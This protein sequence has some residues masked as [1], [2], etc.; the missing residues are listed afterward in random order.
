MISKKIVGID[1]GKIEVEVKAPNPNYDYEFDRLDRMGCYSINEIHDRLECMG[2]SPDILSRNT[3]LVKDISFI[4]LFY[5]LDGMTTYDLVYLL[6]KIKNNNIVKIMVDK[7]I[8]SRN[9]K[10]ETNQPHTK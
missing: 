8:H 4:K 2:I 3:I 10:L 9:L 1:G 7:I 6:S 5:T